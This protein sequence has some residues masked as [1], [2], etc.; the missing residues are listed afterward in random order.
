MGRLPRAHG[1]RSRPPGRNS[2]ADVRPSVVAGRVF[3]IV[4]TG[5]II[6]GTIGPM[7]GGSIMDHGQLRLVFYASVC[8]MLLTVAMA[9]RSERRS[10]RRAL[11]PAE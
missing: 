11:V 10:K 7:L 8:F 1:S 2:N 9:L 5:F 4:T 6:C 3:G